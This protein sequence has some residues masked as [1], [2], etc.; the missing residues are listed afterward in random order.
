MRPDKYSDHVNG[1]YK[2]GCVA[3]TNSGAA[4]MEIVAGG[5]AEYASERR[6]FCVLGLARCCTAL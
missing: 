5:Y 3:L 1:L 2:A 6:T 4:V